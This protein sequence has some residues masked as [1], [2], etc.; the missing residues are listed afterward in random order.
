MYSRSRPYRRAPLSDSHQGTTRTTQQQPWHSQ[1]GSPSRFHIGLGNQRLTAQPLLRDTHPPLQVPRW[2]LVLLDG[3]SD[4]SS[5]AQGQTPDPSSANHMLSLQKELGVS[6]WQ[7]F[8]KKKK[9]LVC[10]KLEMK[11]RGGTRFSVWGAPVTLQPLGSTQ[12]IRLSSHFLLML[13]QAPLLSAIPESPANVFS[14]QGAEDCR[15]IKAAVHQPR[16]LV[17]PLACD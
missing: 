9:K 14:F 12:P 17:E 8:V 1:D 5:L 15:Q 13:T 16:K 3:P 4:H 7:R 6:K 11:D 2:V 10:R